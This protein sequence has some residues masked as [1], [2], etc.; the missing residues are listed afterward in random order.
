MIIKNKLIHLGL[1]GALLSFGSCSERQQPP[2]REEFNQYSTIAVDIPKMGAEKWVLYDLDNDRKVDVIKSVGC[3]QPLFIKKGYEKF[4]DMR[5]G[6]GT[7]ELSSEVEEPAS[8]VLTSL[9]DLGY[10]IAKTRYNQNKPKTNDI[11]G[12]K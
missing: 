9:Q 8:R 12:A 11:T 3:P 7:M 10:E 6:Y 4:F 2:T 1:I 5:E